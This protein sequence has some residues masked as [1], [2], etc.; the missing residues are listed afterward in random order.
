MIIAILMM[1]AATADPAIAPLDRNRDQLTRDVIVSCTSR[2][3]PCVKRMVSELSRLRIAWDSPATSDDER[4]QMRSIIDQNTIAG[5]IDWFSVAPAYFDQR[6]AGRVAAGE[7]IVGQQHKAGTR[8][9]RTRTVTTECDTY[10]S[11]SG[12]H[13]RSRCT[14]QTK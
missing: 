2:D 1:Q 5:G 3:L 4:K 9:D 10:V 6:N 12:N 13:S 11:P 7:I 8:N 14:T